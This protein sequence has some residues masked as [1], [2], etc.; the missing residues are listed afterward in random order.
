M[1]PAPPPAGMVWEC[2][3]GTMLAPISSGTGHFTDH[4][5]VSKGQTQ[6]SCELACNGVNGCATV[7]WHEAPTN[8]C[9]VLTGN[10]SHAEFMK[11]LTPASK[12]PDLYTACILVA[13]Q[14]A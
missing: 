4:D 14:E 2:H 9:H 8:H 5:I 3:P 11:H 6:Q 1:G 12:E 7:N 10:V 13:K